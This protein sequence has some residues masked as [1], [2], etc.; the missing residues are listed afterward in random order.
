[1][2][3]VDKLDDLPLPA[4]DFLAPRDFRVHRKRGVMLSFSRG[5]PHACSFCVTRDIFG[6]RH[7]AMGLSR[8]MA[9]IVDCHERHGALLFD[10][11]DDNFFAN[12]DADAL[13]EEMTAYGRRRGVEFDLVAMNGL[14]VEGLNPERLRLMRRAGFRDLDLSLVTG[15]A[16]RQRGLGRPADSDRFA[17]IV[18]EARKLEMPVRAYFILGLPE[19][20]EE[21]ALATIATIR[22]AGARPVPSVYYDTMKPEPADWLIQR[23]SAF[24]N[25][26]AALPREK[27]LRIFNELTGRW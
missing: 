19:Q 4:R 27:L 9:E 12:P 22:E 26:S 1:L 21:E 7:R 11:E 18:R 17:E 5:C 24:A 25:E 20:T 6:P 3:P 23:S 16:R 8:M 14:G 2:A 10:F 15:D 13:L